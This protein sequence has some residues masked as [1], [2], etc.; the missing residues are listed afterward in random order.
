[1]AKNLPISGRQTRAASS[2]KSSVR[3][4]RKPAQ[5][6]KRD[7]ARSKRAILDASLIEFS[8]YGHAGARID[9][10]AE[11]AGVSKPLIYSYFGDKDQL[12]AAALREAYVQ[13]RE[14]E[15]D[16]DLDHKDPETAIRDLVDFTLRHFM[17][18]PW[19]ISM[20]N[21]ENLR[22]GE[23]IRQIKDVAD[24]QSPLT[25][26]LRSLLDRGVAMGVFRPGIAP[27]DLY[28]SIASLCYFPISNMHTLRAVFHA[29]I[30]DAWLDQRSD[31]IGEMVIRFLRPDPKD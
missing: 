6:Q 9:M 1:M 18:K 28:I 25:D 30:D 19:F 3:T 7:A 15:R 10:I 26:E 23:T 4:A 5:S 24:I 13:I 2:R 17:Q 14:G 21:T 8:T 11:R 12:Y 22:G 29:P 20:L 27:T 31:D 16:L